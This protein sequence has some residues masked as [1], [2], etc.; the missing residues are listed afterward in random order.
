MAGAVVAYLYNKWVTH[1]PIRMIRH[2]WLS[3][4]LGGF[5]TG[6]SVDMSCRFL[7]AKKLNLGDRNVLNFGTLMDGRHYRITTGHDVSIGP[8]AVI[9]TLGHDPQSA[10]FADRGGNVEISDYVWIGYGAIIC[11]G[12]K[13]GEGAI[14]GAGAVV[15]KSVDAWTIV[16]GNPARII[17]TRDRSASYKLNYQPFLL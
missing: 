17:G 3:V 16:A 2:K 11:P 12:V 10:C 14:I 4:I 8:A 5:G 6:S 9:L 1:I 7:N 15:S 13:I